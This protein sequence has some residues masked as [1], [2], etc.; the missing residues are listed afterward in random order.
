MSDK[1]N[2]L[3]LAEFDE[4]EQLGSAI[5]KEY[6]QGNLKENDAITQCENIFIYAF[7]KGIRI[8]YEDLDLDEADIA[9]F[10]DYFN[11]NPEVVNYTINH[12][13][14]GKTW[15]ERLLDHLQNL[16]G[17]YSIKKLVVTEYHRDVNAGIEDLGHLFKDAKEETV[18]K[19][20][21]TMGDDKVRDSHSYLD[22]VKVKLDEDFY[23]YNGDHA[24]Y[25]GM[26]GNAEEDCN[27]RCRVQLTRN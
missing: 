2:Q 22:G 16:D 5:Y 7:F 12:F 13:I 18:Y 24:P 8:G 9:F 15:R 6:V 4:I 19:K 1:G 23:T 20:W 26:F 3:Y 10:E 27:C 17:E 21:I 11:K 25:P 14:D